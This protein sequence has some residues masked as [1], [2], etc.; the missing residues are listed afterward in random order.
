MKVTITA[1]LIFNFFITVSAFSALDD[2]YGYSVANIGD[3][4]N[5]G[6]DDAAA[7]APQNDDRDDNAGKVLIFMGGSEYDLIPD[8]EIYGSISGATNENFG[9]S[10]SGAGDVNNDGYDDIIVGAP[11]YGLATG[12]VY[13][14][15]GSASV[16]TSADLILTGTSGS[17]FGNSVSG[18]GDINNDGFDDVITG[19]SQYNSNTGRAFIFLGGSPMNATIDLTM[20]GIG[21][22]NLL[23]TSV[24]K[25]GDVNNDNFD[26][27]IVGSPGN[28]SSNGRANIYFGSAVLNNSADVIVTG[29]ASFGYFGTSVSNAGDVNNDGFD[30]VVVGAY[31]LNSSSGRIYIYFGGAVMNNVSDRDISGNSGNEFGY[32]VS[33]AGDVNNDGYDD[34][35][36]SAPSSSAGDIYIFYGGTTIDSIPDVQYSGENTGD[37][38]GYSV[39]S[40]GDMNNDTLSDLISGAYGFNVFAGNVYIYIQS[41][42]ALILTKVIPE[43]YYI[44]STNQLQSDDTVRLY[45]H[46]S[47]SPYSLVDSSIA[48]INYNDYMGI[49]SFPYASNGTYFLKVIH[50]N[51]IETWSQSGGMLFSENSIMNYNFT[52]L[53]LKAFGNN[54]IQVDNS[55]VRFG[56]YSGDVNQDGVIDASDNGAIDNDASNFATGYINTDLNGD[57]VID[58]TD[59]AFADN[60]ASNFVSSVRP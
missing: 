55:P 54:M 20:T 9:Y 43:A 29:Q 10:V 2:Q 19:A 58:A 47:V 46:S 48:V 51:S 21:T 8:Y 7:G 27:F 53:Q 59:A 60:N 30:D 45:L 6:Y 37:K 12:R 36:A 34:F 13:I 44:S 4:N 31:G 35:V 33:D 42:V 1:I 40:A 25:A 57:T 52:N 3:I 56:I 18:A 38:Y 50:R 14:F 23:G 32:C 28:S 49:F 16:D 24:S 26:D 15:F 39:S 17:F 11:N 22:G 41:N 5:D